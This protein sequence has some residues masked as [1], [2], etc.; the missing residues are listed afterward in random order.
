MVEGNKSSTY[1]P[2]SQEW[3]QSNIKRIG[4]SLDFSNHGLSRTKKK[5]VLFLKKSAVKYNSFT[6]RK[7]SKPL[8][9]T[10]WACSK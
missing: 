9:I 2:L 1:Y 6:K 8:N 5:R 7:T 4:Q 10:K 3:N